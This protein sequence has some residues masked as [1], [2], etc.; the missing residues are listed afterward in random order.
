MIVGTLYKKNSGKRPNEEDDTYKSK[1]LKTEDNEDGND[2]DN[3]D[4]NSVRQYEPKDLTQLEGQLCVMP[5]L[6]KDHVPLETKR[7]ASSEYRDTKQARCCKNGWKK[8]ES[9]STKD[10]D[11]ART[12][13]GSVDSSR[14]HW[15]ASTSNERLDSDHHHDI[16]INGY[17]RND[18]R[19]GSSSSRS[20]SKSRSD[21]GSSN[22]H[23]LR[24]KSSRTYRDRKYDDY[25]YVSRHKNDWPR[26][27]YDSKETD[28]VRTRYGSKDR[29]DLRDRLR[30][31]TSDIE[32]RERRSGSYK[33]KKY[34][35]RRPQETTATVSE[36][37]RS[38][39]GSKAMIE[40]DS[41]TSSSQT[42]VNTTVDHGVE[43][44]AEQHSTKNEPCASASSVENA[45]T[46]V[47]A[48]DRTNL[49]EG[50]IID[51][52]KKKLDFTKLSANQVM[53][54]NVAKNIQVEDTSNNVPV[55]DQTVHI[56][57]R[58]FNQILQDT[59][60][61]TVTT[62][63]LEEMAGTSTGETEAATSLLLGIA[64]DKVREETTQLNPAGELVTMTDSLHNDSDMSSKKSKYTYFVL[65]SLTSEAMCSNNNY[66]G[67][68]INCLDENSRDDT[69]DSFVRLEE[70]YDFYNGDAGTS[71]ERNND[72]AEGTTE[73]DKGDNP[74][75]D[76]DI[77]QTD[78]E[79]AKNSAANDTTQVETVPNCD[80]VDRGQV[81]T[82]NET[83]RQILDNSN[84]EASRACL[85]DH[86]YVRDAVIE[87]S[88]LDAIPNV[89]ECRESALD[90]ATS[91]DT[92]AEKTTN[93]QS[94]D[95]KKTSLTVKNKKD[96]NSKSVV[97]SRRRKAVTLSDSNASM[98]VLINRDST[99][100]SLVDNSA[101]DKSDSVSKP[102]ACKLARTVKPPCK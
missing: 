23:R 62:K 76:N 69:N 28:G 31:T 11:D 29:G 5:S 18:Y 78:C 10:Y 79:D 60:T 46:C 84:A 19:H 21:Y 54:E 80:S 82:G 98:T 71:G 47:T 22:S 12:N 27:G 49:E 95:T 70:M 16:Y 45:S 3:I 56:K 41:R 26:R 66:V 90:T 9:S 99:R 89:S 40:I 81:S 36:D 101:S 52:P 53:E 86:N 73:V 65:D 91:K 59:V 63:Q 25:R 44:N 64:E 48:N 85:G 77:R 58:D 39:K 51:S 6:K 7:R 61:I 13:K 75:T 50:E 34:D 42:V 68:C 15:A 1:R 100:L 92:E 38:H 55:G 35:N 32:D 83:S 94:V 17:R 14:N 67:D 96:Q 8:E 74:G 20:Y 93:I 2:D 4:Y 97:I 88:N 102:R 57:S 30:H 37:K 24:E 43:K 72:N 33:S 87:A